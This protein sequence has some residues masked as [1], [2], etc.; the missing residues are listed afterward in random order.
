MMVGVVDSDGLMGLRELLWNFLVHVVSNKEIKLD[1][2][3]SMS[4]I[5]RRNFALI[6]WGPGGDSS[7]RLLNR[8][9]LEILE[10]VCHR[11]GTSWLSQWHVFIEEALRWSVGVPWRTSVPGY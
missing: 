1:L 8:E 7:A 9:L 11:P 3:K 2:V 6:S 4:R 5:H 10:N